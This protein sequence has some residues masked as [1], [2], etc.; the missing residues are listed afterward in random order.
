MRAKPMVINTWPSVWP[1]SRRRNNRSM[2]TPINAM[3]SAPASSAAAKL[4]VRH[5]TDRPTYPPSMKYEPW[6]R[7]TIRMMPKISDSPAASRKSR[8]PYDTPLKAWMIQN[9][10][11]TPAPRGLRQAEQPRRVVAQDLRLVRLPQCEPLH[12]H[13]ARP[14]VAHVEAEVTADHDAVGADESDEVLEGLGRVTDRVV[15]E[16]AQVC[17]AAVPGA[18]ARPAPVPGPAWGA[19]RSRRNGRGAPCAPPRP[20]R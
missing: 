16:A 17:R 7:L 3:A 15:A 6:A 1:A 2:P 4:C 12:H 11:V 8:A 5:T 10:A 13:V 14:L 19:P 9:S 20:R 18:R